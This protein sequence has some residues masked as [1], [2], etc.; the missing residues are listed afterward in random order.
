[1]TLFLMYFLIAH[2]FILISKVSDV[3]RR[4]CIFATAVTFYSG[5]KLPNT[6]W[7][8]SNTHLCV[9]DHDCKPFKCIKKV[10]LTKV[11]N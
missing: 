8:L 4:V 5:L 11:P 3:H 7:D 2:Q 10:E 1:M 9:M 6:G